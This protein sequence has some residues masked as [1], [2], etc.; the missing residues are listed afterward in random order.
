MTAKIERA[1]PTA[2]LQQTL[3]AL[4][5]ARAKLAQL[6]EPIA[7]VGMSCRF[8][9]A[10]SLDAYWDLLRNGV[11]AI[12]EVPTSRWDIDLYYD[13]NRDVPGK[14]YTRSGGFIA[15]V[16]R[17][18]P[19]FFGISPREAQWM[20][21]QHRLLLEVSWEALE[22]ASIVPGSLRGTATGVFI[23]IT[24]SDYARLLTKNGDLS[25]IGLH[26]ITGNNLN[27]AAGRLSYTYG[28]QGPALAVDTAC[29]SS[30]M[31]LHLACQS[32]RNGEC[33]MAL[34]GGVNLVLLP[35]GLVAGSRAHTL[36]PDGR[37]K[38]F[39]A[40]ADGYV[41]GEGC[42]V[43]VLQRLSDAR[44]SGKTIL[45]VIR[46]SAANQNGQSSGFTVPNGLAQQAVL[47]QALAQA[48]LEPSDVTYVEAHGTGTSL[49]DPIEIRAIGAVMG[50]QREAPIYVGTVKT[51]IGH[52]ESAAGIAGVIKTVLS[53][54]H[55]EIPPNLHF[56][57]PNPHIPWDELA[58]QV[59]TERMRWPAERKRVA[60]VSSIGVSGTNVHVLLEAGTTE[61]SGSAVAAARGERPWDL[62]TLSAKSEAALRAL[63]ERYVHCFKAQPALAWAAVCSTSHTGRSHFPHRMSI[64]AN[65]VA[66]AAEAMTAQLADSSGD[67]SIAIGQVSTSGRPK[68][69]F[70]FTGQ[71]SQYAG[72]GQELY[73]TQPAFRQVLDRCEASFLEQVG[74]SLLDLIYP[75]SGTAHKDLL[76]SHHCGQAVNFAI[77]CALV[78]LWRA[79]GI[80]PDVVLG[81]SLGDFAAAYAAGVLRLEDGLRLVTLRGQLMERAA[82]MMFSVIASADELAPFLASC[83]AVTIAAIN[84]PKSVVISGNEAQTS[85]VAERI[86]AAGFTIRKLAIP[87]A[88]HSPMLDPVLDEFEAAV[89]QVPLSAPQRKV[90]SS[91]TGELVTD[92]LTDPRY[93]RRHLRSTVRFAAGL[94]A[95]AAQ[96]VTLCLEIGPQPTL[97]GMLEQSLGESDGVYSAQKSRWQPILLPSLRDSRGPWQQVLESLGQLYVHGVEINWSEFD[98]DLPRRSV[99]LPTYP[100]QRQ[101]CWFEGGEPAA[102]QVGIGK[103]P[104]P[105][106]PSSLAHLLELGN[107]PE[108]TQRLRSGG[109]F[110]DPELGL[111]PGLLQ[112]LVESYQSEQCTS[113]AETWLHEVSWK[114]APA[115][116]ALPSDEPGRWLILADRGGVGDLLARELTRAG[117]VVQVVYACA[118]GEKSDASG[119]VDPCDPQALSA[120]VDQALHSAGTQLA[121]RA[122]VDL[123][124]L[125]LPS[126]EDLPLSQLVQ[127]QRLGCG[128]LIH[129]VQALL[130]DDAD[131]AGALPRIWVVTRGVHAIEPQPSRRGLH[132]TQAPLWGLGRVLSLE[133]PDLWGGLLDLSADEDMDHQHEV[134]GL[135]S[136][137]LA[138]P[139][140]EQVAYRA[141]KRMVARLVRSLGPPAVSQAAWNIDQA[142]TY[143]ITGGLGGLGLHIARQL[144]E[145]GA[146][147]LVLTGR[148]GVST[149]T[150]QSNVN[151]LRAMGVDV[152]VE[153]VDVADEV[154]MTQLLGRLTSGPS[155]LRGVVHSAGTLADGIT[156]LQTWERFESV[157]AS[158]VTGSW[159]LHT[160]T[161][162]LELDFFV[163]FSSMSSVL[164]VPGQG[165]YAAANAFMDALAHHR[166]ALGLPGLSINWGVWAAEGMTLRT[167]RILQHGMS[168]I[169]PKQ[170]R[171]LFAKLLHQQRSQVAV[172]PDF[173]PVGVESPFIELLVEPASPPVVRERSFRQRLVE[174][175]AGTQLVLLCEHVR[176][177]VAQVLGFRSAETIEDQMVF[178]ALGMDSLMTVELRNRLQ[179]SLELQLSATVAF[180]YP[181]I[182][183]LCGYLAQLLDSATI[184]RGDDRPDA[185]RRGAAAGRVAVE[186]AGPIDDLSEQAVG[187]LLDQELSELSGYWTE[188]PSK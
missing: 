115:A 159:L 145:E 105:R 42:G 137:L 55:E 64:V 158:K 126:A 52:L 182:E 153:Q 65:S 162:N 67:P 138:P 27:A 24:M 41:R 77:E 130:R 101:H 116:Q 82:G 38:S 78:E 31:A 178:S 11:D 71:G 45:A 164:G 108:L 177:Q 139:C 160:L 68:L 186:Q 114:A 44:A 187:D 131:V 171:E 5:E 127:A 107:I 66:V 3:V 33:S 168:M 46:G 166:R 1:N 37:C 87:V 39:D 79:W 14:C 76:A 109:R 170:G 10:P 112:T 28:L 58:V 56:K 89:R 136:E 21:P 154:G 73:S 163:C 93:W 35:D 94:D 8:P 61:P 140:G 174:V 29:S 50:T 106:D 2:V 134:A 54:Q 80:E 22:N 49:G 125:D 157:M 92:E 132:I 18:D 32:L 183:G 85:E 167:P 156:L 9:G 113:A 111:L 86:G 26:H 141:G 123:W 83:E 128:A 161:R 81:H 149:A 70:L 155:P 51:N 34:A 169:P 88:A 120:V 110:S 184:K 4:K 150:Q 90:I 36:A 63:C 60:G 47:R 121:F 19:S 133:H 98:R 13:P 95:M 23:G 180:N 188:E 148:Q 181:S 173:H 104:R 84:G 151:Q 100:F 40:A 103:P 74:R 6:K 102:A 96:G 72:M 69:A 62:L 15:D 12:S 59:P 143:L 91:M 175:P 53:L 146:R 119:T 185:D 176:T 142:A 124:S 117:H 99:P 48:A 17:F 172:V 20:D 97:L 165:N 147:R 129:L 135:L 57:T 25:Q 30:L 75:A 152:Q 122:V 179:R 144:A 118:P 43:I 7:I 16:D